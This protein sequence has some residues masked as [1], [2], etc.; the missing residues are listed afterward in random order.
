[1]PVVRST[2]STAKSFSWSFSRLKAFEDCPRRYHEVQVLKKWPEERSEQLKRGD[3]VHDAMALAL[4]GG[5]PL[6]EKYATYQPWIDKVVRTKG[7]L[8]VEEQCKWAIDRDFQPVEWFAPK[9][10][11]RCIADAVVVDDI[12]ALVVDWKGLSIDT[13]IPTINGF[14]YMADIRINDLVVGTD[15]KFYPVIG[16]SETRQIPCYRV[17]FTSGFAIICD[18]N[19]LWMLENSTVVPVAELQQGH[20]IPLPS[21]VDYPTQDLP[22][23]PY[24]LGIWLA[25]G[26][27]TSGE[28]S[29]PDEE[30]WAEIKQRG[31]TVGDDISGDAGKCCTRTV[32]DIRGKLADLDVLNNK[33]I[34]EI[35]LRSSIAQR[36][37]L[38]AG[39]MDGDGYANPTRK[40]A[41]VDMT[42][43]TLLLQIGELTRSLGERVLITTFTKSGFGK[44]V[45]VWRAAW[46]PR[47]NPFLLPRKN[48]I[49]AQFEIG[50]E[51]LEVA[52]VVPI[53]P[54]PTKCISVASP[55]NTFLCGREYVVTHNTG[56]SSNVDV[57]QLTLTS[58]MMFIQYP[59]LLR[60]RSEFVWLP[61]DAQTTLMID[62][63]EAGEEWGALLPRVKKL[64]QAVLDNNFPPKPNNFCKRYC[65]VKS[66]EFNGK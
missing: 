54:E 1:M 10:W 16:V 57:V 27:H 7:E 12:C 63:H 38:L 17:E 66:C 13:P 23:D 42:N 58:L 41:V 9:A 6:P 62:R 55:D 3:E 52:D 11:L 49:A 28:I 53:A 51:Y 40:Q 36:R 65:S 37:D 26:K 21:P 45:T 18:E 29:K 35:Y 14:K 20:K 5:K 61:E 4:I 64:E 39:L 56:K 25:D 59:E 24:I 31:Y 19:H 43:Q 8:L 22:I 32:Y 50:R 30:I 2:V 47:H 33:H 60:V 44:T 46:R 15:G 34:P 48:T